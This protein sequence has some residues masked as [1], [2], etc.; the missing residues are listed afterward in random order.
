MTNKFHARK[1]IYN[2]QRFDSQKEAQRYAELRLMQRAGKIQGLETQVPYELV[3]AQRDASGKLAERA[4]IYKADFV[5]EENGDVVVEDVKSEATRTPEYII[6]R[7]LM[8]WVHGI[9]IREV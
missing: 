5:Y 8:R 4:V 2:G 3:P 9:E 6:K 7:K 1:V